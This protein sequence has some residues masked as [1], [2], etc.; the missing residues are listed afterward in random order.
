MGTTIACAQCHDH[1]Y[2]PLT[3]EEYFKLFAFFNNTQ[4]RDLKDE[5][6]L[7]SFFTEE[8]NRGRRA[9]N[10]RWP[11]SSRRLRRPLL[12]WSPV[13]S[14]GRIRSR[15]SSDGSR[16][17][18]AMTPQSAAK[19]SLL[20]DQSILAETAGANT[21]VYTLK[22]AAEGERLTA[23]S[24]RDAAAR[25]AARSGAGPC[26]WG[27]FMISRVLAAVV[28]PGDAKPVGR[29]VRVEIPG[30]NKILSLAE[31]QVFQGGENRAPREPPPRAVPG[32]MA[33]PVWRSTATPTATT[34]RR[35]RRRTPRRPTTHGGNSTSSKLS[36]SIGSRSGTGPTAK[37][38]P[39]SMDVGS[40]CSTRNAARLDTTHGNGPRLE[41]Q[42]I[43]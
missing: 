30:K 2:D 24:A 38:T 33:R 11:P 35:N 13:S 26:A 17:P 22:L 16:S 8:Q 39:G 4:D 28:P 14:G 31:V 32:S 25:I 27:N 29:F 21:D 23:A 6:P 7:I 36:R 1:K 9:W 18:A 3:Q 34:R 37:S 20:D 42:S 19:L 15:P 40:P 10:A 41:P 43:R 12:N 5:S